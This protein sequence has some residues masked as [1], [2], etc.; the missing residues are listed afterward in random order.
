MVIKDQM[1]N[2]Y[3]NIPPEQ[4]PWNIETPPEVLRQLVEKKIIKPCKAIELGCGIGNYV[5]YLAENGFTATGVDIS[6]A[7]IE[8]AQK[9]S[10]SKGVH[11]QRLAAVKASHKPRP[12]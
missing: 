4:I 3:K 12:P 2:I 8:L 1:E 10:Q 5:T 11:S 7:A 9:S 6:E